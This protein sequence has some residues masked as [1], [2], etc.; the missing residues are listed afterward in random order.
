MRKT[1]TKQSLLHV[2]A[3]LV[4]VQAHDPN[5]TLKG[6]DLNIDGGALGGFTDDLHNVIPLPIAFEIFSDELEGVEEGSDSGL[7][8]LWRWLFLPCT[9][10]DGSE[11]LIR[12]PL[13]AFWF[14]LAIKGC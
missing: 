4:V 6:T 3:H 8:D 1:Y 5:Q 14:L 13:Q 7:L 10:N 9:M 12:S 2:K 11:N